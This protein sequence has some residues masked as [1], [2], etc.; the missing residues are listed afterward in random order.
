MPLP[1]TR[2]QRRA[3]AALHPDTASSKGTS[4]SSKGGEG[5]AKEGTAKE[6]A[7]DSLKVVY[8]PSCINQRMGLA[9]ETKHDAIC[10]PHQPLINDLTELLVKAG[11][12]V[13]FPEHMGE[14]CCGTIWESK[15]MPEL[16]DQKSAEL[17]AALRVASHD[18]EYPIL[19][20][21]SPCL[22]RMRRTMPSLT[23]YEPAE[24]ID[25]FLLPRLVI[26]PLDATIAVHLT[27]STRKLHLSDA[28]LR[29]ARA[30]AREVILPEGVGCC[31]FAGDKGFTDPELNAWALRHLRSEIEKHHVTLGVSNSRTCEIGL[32]H[33]S[34]ITYINIASLVN[35]CSQPLP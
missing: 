24:F 16:A 14:L 34:G 9:K 1:V 10:L 2:R 17:E 8:F 13:I 30:C 18:G 15:G 19:C 25:R 7:A 26:T 11:Y 23:L 32:C 22:Y 3:A 27:C 29:V 28:L 31:G 21:Q 4:A 33:H 20:D 6:G 35:Q 5:T 12:E